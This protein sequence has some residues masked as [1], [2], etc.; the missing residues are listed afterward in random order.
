VADAAAPSG[1][2]RAADLGRVAVA[3]GPA[4][5][6]AGLQLLVFV[7]TAR[8]LGPAAFGAL[9]VV[10]AVSAIATDAA[11][12][13]GD[14]AMVRATARNP[15]VFGR[16]WGHALALLALSF[17]PVAAAAALVAALLAPGIGPVPVLLLVTGEIA[18][19]RAT[20]AAELAFVAHGT[21]LGASL[22]RLG[23]VAARALTAVAVFAIAGATDIGTWAVAAC[24]Q[25]F[26]TAAAVVA[27]AS[28]RYGRPRAGLDGGEIG[29]GLLLMLGQL[30][31]SLNA[32]LDRVVL[33]AIL[34]PA[35]LGVYASAARLQ[36]VGAILMQAAT[37]LTLPRFFRAADRPA[38][39]RVTRDAAR[40]MAAVGLL[41]LA[42][43]VVAAQALPL[44]LGPEF[45]G[46]VP[47]ATGLA[48]ACPFVALQYP[49][50]DALTAAG[51]Q[52]LR[53]ALAWA[54]AP[55]AAGLLVVGAR[56]AGAEGA[57][58][59]FVAAQALH[60]AALWAASAR[61]AR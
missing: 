15:A 49:P 42:L 11:G 36:L 54:A 60:A 24:G 50:A 13:G 53:T 29:F 20:A 35:A 37:R 21:P 28:A 12:L 26:V 58:A 22:L 2:R 30:A 27:L 56:A 61:W 59:G 34:A 17:L 1:A 32:N 3:V 16:A 45:A 4:A 43:T 51:R 40:L 10:Y 38:L 33:A 46:L 47:L 5:V 52:G 41:A 25:S 44:V 14:Q 39:G 55:A 18:V 9:A 57:V 48:L 6:A 8:A 23:S 19:G 7:L 31:R